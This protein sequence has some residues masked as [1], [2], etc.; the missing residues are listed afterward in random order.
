MTFD[1][2]DKH[3]VGS[4][5]LFIFYLVDFDLFFSDIRGDTT[6][7]VPNGTALRISI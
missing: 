5:R 6:G 4:L 1:Q 7:N 3:R 2:I